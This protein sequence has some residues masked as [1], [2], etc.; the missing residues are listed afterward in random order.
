MGRYDSIQQQQK[1]ERPWTV[2]PIW[3]GIG[4]IFLVLIPI[5]SYLSATLIVDANVE[6]RWIPIPDILWGP[7]QFPLLY[8]NL[9][10]TV[11]LTI[12]AFGVLLIIYS[13]FYSSLGPPKYGPMDAPPPKKK[14]VRKTKKNLDQNF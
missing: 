1:P 8:A 2:H 12:L 4:C 10:A 3:R 13:F 14:R 9:V 6:N 5:L 11:F 7:S